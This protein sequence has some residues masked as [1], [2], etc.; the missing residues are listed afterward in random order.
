M[1][2]A[3]Y[4]SKIVAEAHD[5]ANYMMSSHGLKDA[6]RVIMWFNEYN[7]FRAME[8]GGQGRPYFLRHDREVHR[9][10]DRLWKPLSE[11]LKGL[12]QTSIK[13]TKHITSR[14]KHGAVPTRTLS[15]ITPDE[16]D[17]FYAECVA[18]PPRGPSYGFVTFPPGVQYQDHPLVRRWFGSRM[19]ELNTGMENTIRLLN[20]MH[21]RDLLSG[22]ARD[23]IVSI[24][25]PI[26]RQIT[27]KVKDLHA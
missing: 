1:E 27:D 10:F 9:H 15:G 12:G 8:H 5:I 16:M 6:P 2:V 17:E 26:A 23:K 22:R 19:Q 21:D 4:R 24:P 14:L 25:G 18:R 3:T 20:L 11:V 13:V 7:A